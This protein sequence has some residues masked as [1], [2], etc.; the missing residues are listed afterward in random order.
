MFGCLSD[1]GSFN[2]FERFLAHKQT[3]FPITL[4]N[5]EFVSTSTTT[6]TTYLGSRAVV[7]FII[8]IKYMVDQHPFLLETLAQV[9]N[10]TF[11]FQQHFK[12]ASDLLSLPTHTC[13]LSFEQLIGQ[14]MVCLQNSILMQ[15]HH[16]TIF[17]M[18]FD[19]I[20]E[21]HHVHIFSCYGFGA[22]VWFTTSSIFL[23][24][25]FFYFIFAQCFV[26]DLNYPILLL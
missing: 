2:N 25:Q 26:C 20:S 6:P 4:S 22:N 19:K 9:N 17:S 5:F 13:I 3:F 11:I 23:T 12:A 8:T 10:N 21:A 7:V 24:F 14:Q 1:Q 16:H 18:F 15:L